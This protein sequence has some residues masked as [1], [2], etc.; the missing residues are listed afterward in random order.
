MTHKQ[1]FFTGLITS[2]ILLLSGCS[3]FGIKGE[4]ELLSYPVE[5]ETIDNLQLDI[6]AKLY[7]TQ[8]ESQEVV[9][10]AQDNVFQNLNKTAENGT[11]E[12]EF[13]KP[14]RNMK[15]VNI[16][17]TV[18]TLKAVGVDGSGYVKAENQFTELDKLQLD[19]NGSG[20]IEM[21][22]LMQECITNI[23]GSGMITLN[24]Q[25]DKLACNIDGSGKIEAFSAPTQSAKINLVGSGIIETDAEKTL[26]INI[27]GS[28]KVFYRGQAQITNLSVEG[29]GK[30]VKKD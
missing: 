2:L 9:I 28:G 1:T 5:M 19:I 23:V 27:E 8:G 13:D 10:E 26:D 6:P 22:A 24:G 21:D 29:S 17:V 20:A 3:G 14:V 15:Q 11:W 7:I 18:N 30:A 16:Y 25:S 4:G 12:I